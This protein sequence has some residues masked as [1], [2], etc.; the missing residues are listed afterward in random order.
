M[1]IV[2]WMWIVW[3]A[4]L[5]VFI[6]FRVYVYRMSRNEDDQLALQDSSAH[7]R[8]EQ[9]AIAARLEGARPV[10]RAILAV[11]G[12]MTIYV[13]GYYVLDMVRQFR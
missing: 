7:L 10:G 9:E 12:A 13:A 11:F 8:Q 1:P 5:I 6:A 4:L 3:V 2:P